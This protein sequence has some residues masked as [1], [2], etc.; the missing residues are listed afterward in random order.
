MNYNDV[1]KDTFS[2]YSP[3][4][5]A[6]NAPIIVPIP[7]EPVDPPVPPEPPVPPTPTPTVDR[8]YLCFQN[9]EAVN[10]TITLE[11][12]G[13]PTYS[14]TCEYTKD[15]D[16]WTVMNLTPDANGVCDSIVLQ[17]NEKVWLRGTGT[18]ELEGSSGDFYQYYFQSTGLL[19]MSGNLLSIWDKATF[20]TM[21]QMPNNT[22]MYFL[23]KYGTTAKSHLKVRN[24][25]LS[26]DKIV[27]VSQTNASK[28]NRC[29]I[30][31]LFSGFQASPNTY[32][33]SC[34]IHFDS[35]ITVN[36]IS[37]SYSVCPFASFFAYCT[38]IT[39][40]WLPDWTGTGSWGQTNFLQ[41]VTTEGTIYLPKG[42]SISTGATIRP[43]TWTVKHYDPATGEIID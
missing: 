39:E 42:K 11:R 40:V 20:D 6:A 10:N 24:A 23:Q 33:Q 18:W 43:L 19:D 17:P 21:T 30:S 31:A 12:Q 28:P 38:N 36:R 22:T 16:T 9:V 2:K 25:D 4:G 1:F 13:E 26:F 14:V 34:K 15:G 29:V 27:T 35:Q 5:G 32:L 37:G 41:G 7:V 8:N 3:N